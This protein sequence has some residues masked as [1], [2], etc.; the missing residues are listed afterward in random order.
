MQVPRTPPL[1]GGPPLSRGL[2][3]G[4]REGSSQ[5]SLEGQG[6]FLLGSSEG[7]LE[8]LVKFWT[9]GTRKVNITGV[10]TNITSKFTD[11]LGLDCM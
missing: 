2:R 11:D 1:V 3:R 7:P 9:R 6:R 5:G 4:G 8:G 10:F